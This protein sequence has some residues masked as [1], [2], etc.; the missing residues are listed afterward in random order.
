MSFTFVVLTSTVQ[1][2]R[3]RLY[4]RRRLLKKYVT[5]IINCIP[6]FINGLTVVSTFSEGR[7]RSGILTL[8]KSCFLMCTNKGR[9]LSN[10]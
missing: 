6:M 8:F 1:L 9:L 3:L 10:K 5:F 2:L 7:V 4:R